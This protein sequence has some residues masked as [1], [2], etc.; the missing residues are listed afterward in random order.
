L[1]NFTAKKP[2]KYSKRVAIIIEN[3]IF[4]NIFD[5]N[6]TGIIHTKLFI[7]FVINKAPKPYIGQN[8]PNKKPLLTICLS[9]T[10]LIIVSNSHPINE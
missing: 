2:T 8:G 6:C 5:A 7:E 1:N 4:I 10:L 3:N 9:R